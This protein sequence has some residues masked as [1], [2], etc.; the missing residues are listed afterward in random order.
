MTS[1]LCHCEGSTKIS[2][3]YDDRYGYPGKFSLM[4]CR[5]CSHTFLEHD[6]TPEQLTDLYSNYYPRSN[7]DLDAYQPYREETGF[8]AWLDGSKISAFRWVPESVRVLDVGCGFGESLGYHTAR[9]CEVYGVEADENIR[10][11]ADKFGYHVHVGLFDPDIYE[12]NFFDYVTMEQVLEHVTDPTGILR[13]VA[14][15]LKSGGTAVVSF[16]NAR[17]WGEKVFGRKWINWH[18]PYHLQFYSRKLLKILTNKAG[19]EIVDDR[20]ITPS[21]WL[22]F[23]WLYLLT[24]PK[25]GEP[26]PFWAGSACG[27]QVESSFFQR[28]IMKLLSMLHRAK[29]N[30]FITRAFDSVGLGDK[31]IV[32]L[33]KQ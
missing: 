6:F 15:I 5:E 21:V 13:G 30:Y 28:L 18:T 19:L 22:Y 7:F 29:F 25:P 2:L 16:P 4:C 9:G 23:Q 32:F 12:E 20:T 24:Y 8:S 26:S 10:R 17:G 3:S 1:E 31:R 14:C 11:V 27:K 33:R